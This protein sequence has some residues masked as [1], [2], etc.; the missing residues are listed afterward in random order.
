MSHAKRTGE[1]NR[2]ER[3]RG[4]CGAGLNPAF[5]VE[6]AIPN[7]SCESLPVVASRPAQRRFRSRWLLRRELAVDRSVGFGGLRGDGSVGDGQIE[8]VHGGQQPGEIAVLAAVPELC[9]GMVY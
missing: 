6:M 9:C 3:R 7:F 5:P 2:T 8:I 1:P 4:E